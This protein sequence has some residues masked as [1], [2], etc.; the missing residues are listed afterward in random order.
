MHGRTDFDPVFRGG[1]ITVTAKYVCGQLSITDKDQRTA[2]Q[3]RAVTAVAT[4]V[5]RTPANGHRLVIS[6][7]Q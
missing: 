7:I 3:D 4:S 1:R 5:T 2:C 6:A